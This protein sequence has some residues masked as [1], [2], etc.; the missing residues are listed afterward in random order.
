[1]KVTLIPNLTKKNAYDTTLNLCT[2]LDSFGI[3]YDFYGDFSGYNVSFVGKK[4]ISSDTDFIIAIGGDGT[5]IR[6]AKAALPFDIPILGINAGTLA[7]LVGL[8]NNEVRLLKKLL[9]GEYTTEERMLIDVSLF[10]ADNQLIK[11][12]NCV[13]DAIFARGSHIKIVSLDFYCDNKFVS[14]YKA[15]GLIVSTPTGSTAYNL[16]AG[17]PIVD[18]A[19]ESILLTPI[20]PHSLDHRTIIFN[21]DSVLKIVNSANNNIVTVSCDGDESINFSTGYSAEIR[22]SKNKIKLIRLK[23]D[24]FMD[25]LNRK[26]KN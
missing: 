6:A 2:A 21:S 17:G 24:S 14:K 5:M 7:F 9:T 13:N 19:L 25:I 20:C 4:N 3:S 15:D 1:M 26:M 22:K 11:T 8:E 18:P 16:A 23:D 10:D 12:E